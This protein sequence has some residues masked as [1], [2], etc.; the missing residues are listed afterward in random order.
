MTSTPARR[1]RRRNHRSPNNADHTHDADHTHTTTPTTPTGAP[2]PNTGVDV[3]GII[4]VALVL[5]GVGALLLVLA[6]RR[7]RGSH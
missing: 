7:R 6:G 5:F 1:S 4:M 2:L 3:G